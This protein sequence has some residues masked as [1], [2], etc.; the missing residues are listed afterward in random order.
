MARVLLLIPADALMGGRV[1]TARYQSV[2]KSVHTME[3]VHY[4]IR[5]RVRR[6]G[7]GMIARYRS[8]PR[9]ASMVDT[10]WRPIHAS[11]TSGP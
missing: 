3:T 2:I 6:V 11:V 4:L 7:R 5:A 1:M 9:T 10:V 8:V